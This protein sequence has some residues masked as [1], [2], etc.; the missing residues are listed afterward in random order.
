MTSTMTFPQL[1]ATF[2]EWKRSSS[3]VSS[4]TLAK[5][6]FLLK[7]DQV[8]CSKCSCP[9]TVLEDAKKHT[10]GSL[11]PGVGPSAAGQASTNDSPASPQMGR[12]MSLES[13]GAAL[14]LSPKPVGKLNIIEKSTAVQPQSKAST[15]PLRASPAEPVLD[16]PSE[17]LIYPQA[18]TIR[19]VEDA[20]MK[21]TRNR[22][23]TY[24]N[25]PRNTPVSPEDL[26][27]AGFYFVGPDDRVKCAYCQKRIRNWE[28]SDDPKA[29]H[30]TLNKSCEFV[31][32]G[33]KK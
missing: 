6:G 10:C 22:M 29:V 7:G 28:K 25:W 4:V 12:Q 18:P 1:L 26:V 11:P 24:K 15:G 30:A 32:S 17:K 14:R 9:L 13:D 16:P 23:Q 21:E 27:N 5:H 33:F 19:T 20:Q 3:H 8:M 2:K 31:Q